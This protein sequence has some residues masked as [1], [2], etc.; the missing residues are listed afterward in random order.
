[1]RFSCRLKL[2]K[3]AVYLLFTLRGYTVWNFAALDPPNMAAV[4]VLPALLLATVTMFSHTVALSNVH[5][6]FGISY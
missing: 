1:M 4:H 3:S 6:R 2:A 5:C